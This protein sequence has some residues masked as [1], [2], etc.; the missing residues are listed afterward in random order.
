M[1]APFVAQIARPPGQQNIP[2][3]IAF[4]V[5]VIALGWCFSVYYRRRKVQIGTG[6]ALFLMTLWTVTILFAMVLLTVIGLQGLSLRPMALYLTVAAGLMLFVRLVNYVR[7]RTSLPDKRDILLTFGRGGPFLNNVQGLGQLLGSL[8]LFGSTLFRPLIRM[9]RQPEP[10]TLIVLA[11]AASWIVLAVLL[12]RRTP[13]YASAERFSIWG[14]TPIDWSEVVGFS[15]VR[16]STK[17]KS[18]L[19]LRLEGSERIEAMIEHHRHELD[20]LLNRYVSTQ[21]HRQFGS[22]STHRLSDRE[23]ETADTMAADLPEIEV[24]TY[25]HSKQSFQESFR[26]LARRNSIT[27][28]I[29]FGASTAAVFVVGCALIGV[30][31]GQLPFPLPTAILFAVVGVLVAF[32]VGFLMRPMLGYLGAAI[33]AQSFDHIAGCPLLAVDGGHGQRADH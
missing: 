29:R 14:R 19:T 33:S 23:G 21:D 10:S 4:V 32:M 16:G 28:S 17:D 9:I 18:R 6:A 12:N 3:I 7:F 1:L 8:A 30:F 13:W 26:R 25:K 20:Q 5:S 15:W 31:L 27:R 22:P 2:L 11:A 24:I